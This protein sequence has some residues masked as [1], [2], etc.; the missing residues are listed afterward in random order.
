MKL[1]C[2]QAKR[3]RWKTHSKTLPDVH[4]RDIDQEVAETI[5]VFVHAEA[6]DA[7]EERY[8]SVS[9]QVLKHIKW[10]ANKRGLKNIVLHSFTHLGG[11]TAQPAVAE[12]FIDVAA[13][14]LRDTGYQVW[15]TPF[16]YFC[17]WDLSVYGESLAKVWKEIH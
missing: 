10:L 1:L 5:V 11:E 15:T 8:G 17:E 9:R 6:S 14:R 7:A 16:G 13:Q 2:F 12:S 4:D 3:F